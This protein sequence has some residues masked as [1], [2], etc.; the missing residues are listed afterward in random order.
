MSVENAGPTAPKVLVIGLD[1]ATPEY[2][3][4]WAQQG[5]LPNLARL[6]DRGA[7]GPTESTTPPFT[8]MA[9]PVFYTGCNAGKTG[10]FSYYDRYRATVRRPATGASVRAKPVWRILRDAGKRSVVVAVPMTYP[11]EKIDGVMISGMDAPS[12]ASPFTH[13]AEIRD[14]LLRQGYRIFVD[15]DLLYSGDTQ[16]IWKEAL[17][18]SRV[19]TE[20][21]TR[22][23]RDEPWDFAMVVLNEI[24]V[25]SHFMIGDPIR[26]FYRETDRL[27]GDILSA[28]D[29]D[30]LVLVISDHGVMPLEGRIFLN[31]VLKDLGL[32]RLRQKGSVTRS[33]A[34]FGITR[35]RVRGLLR[36]LGLAD[37]LRGLL[38][39][40]LWRLQSVLPAAE[41][42]LVDV[43]MEASK[44]VYDGGYW[45]WL[46]RPEEDLSAEELEGLRAAVAPYGGR[47]HRGADLYPGPFANEAP[48]YVFYA[49]RFHP[50]GAIG[51]GAWTGPT[52]IRPGDH[53]MDAVSILS[54]NPALVKTGQLRGQLADWTPT[55][56]Y[57]MGIPIP[58]EVDGRVLTEAIQPALLGARP[59]RTAGKRERLQQRIR[60]LK[61]KRAL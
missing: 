26:E 41:Q 40:S 35:D 14:E 49:P 37:R 59:V 27:V 10:V 7:W 42:R 17:R 8:T 13:P 56:L 23:L 60:G 24:D 18:V 9:W 55:L 39:N 15:R 5:L 47:V 29:E 38:P 30:T 54:G 50:A 21:F 2:L 25:V 45:I 28:V 46:T 4:P 12:E 19:K 6:M 20:V 58:E 22:L 53:S 43:D 1:G 44:A 57:L 31:E 61:V 33:M 48:D 52:T 3:F 16:T 36:S 32:L 34:R 11:P 51:G